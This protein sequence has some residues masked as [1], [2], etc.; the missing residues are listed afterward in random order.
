MVYGLTNYRVTTYETQQ[1]LATTI[2]VIFI[3]IV[4]VET[5]RSVWNALFEQSEQ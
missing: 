3:L 1:F 2:G 5:V 4:V